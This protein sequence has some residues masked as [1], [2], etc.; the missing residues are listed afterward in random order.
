MKVT[1]IL[2][3][4]G[5]E[6]M[7]TAELEPVEIEECEPEEFDTITLD[8]RGIPPEVS[9]Q[10]TSSTVA[11]LN[12]MAWTATGWSPGT[13]EKQIILQLRAT[14]RVAFSKPVGWGMNHAGDNAEG[15]VGTLQLTS[16]RGM[17]VK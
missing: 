8:L 1:E 4:Q 17:G 11:E 14:F 2:G 5:G 10:F 6:A 3:F 9:Q 13:L 15:G 12:R 16:A 7:A